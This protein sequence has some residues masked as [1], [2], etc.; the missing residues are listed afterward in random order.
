MTYAPIF[1]QSFVLFLNLKLPLYAP[2]FVKIWMDP[3]TNQAQIG[4]IPQ[5]PIAN[6][7]NNLR[8]I[9]LC[10]STYKLVTKIITN[11]IK[12]L[13]PSIIWPTQASF[14]FGIRTYFNKIKGKKGS[15]ILKID[16]E[17]DFDRLE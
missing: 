15:I 14:L 13:T 7:F 10:N 9:S 11:R 1:T 16:L 3:R 8:L 6:T 12:P 5:F 4:H 17:K 2:L